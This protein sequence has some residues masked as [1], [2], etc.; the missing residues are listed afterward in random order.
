MHGR[1]IIHKTKRIYTSSE[2]LVK[3]G[4][5]TLKRILGTLTQNGAMGSSNILTRL[6]GG[7]IHTTIPVQTF[8][9]VFSNPTQTTGC[10]LGT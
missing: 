3:T 5:E 10:N 9:G 8:T 2:I 6:H 1:K 7:I 4:E